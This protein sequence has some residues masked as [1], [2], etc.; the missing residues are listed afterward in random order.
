MKKIFLI[1]TKGSAWKTDLID[2]IGKKFD[3]DLD[4]NFIVIDPETSYDE[5]VKKDMTKMNKDFKNADKIVCVLSPNTSGK[6]LYE[7]AQAVDLSNKIPEKLLFAFL[8]RERV[9]N[10]TIHF[11]MADRKVMDDL[12]QMIHN[13]DAVV[14]DNLEEIANELIEFIDPTPQ[15]EPITEDPKTEE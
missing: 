13:N 11:D 8:N 1:G 14:C 15:E 3:P 12:N 4:R 10:V 2:L 5:S 7:V 6:N 9:D